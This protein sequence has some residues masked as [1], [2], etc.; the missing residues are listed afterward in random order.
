MTS[1][2]VE[3]LLQVAAPVAS[4]DEPVGDDGAP[5]AR[6]CCAT[7][8]RTIP[9]R[10]WAS[11]GAPSRALLGGLSPRQREVIVRRFGL[12]GHDAA[13]PEAIALSAR[14]HAVARAAARERGARPHAPPTPS[15][16]TLPPGASPALRLRAMQ[17]AAVA[18]PD[19]AE[20]A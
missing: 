8:T 2:D 10:R 15:R 4:L 14:G 1:A 7:P 3:H 20:A 16:A 17:E 6:P 18:A 19:R 13:T 9:S 12:A 11:T 5:L